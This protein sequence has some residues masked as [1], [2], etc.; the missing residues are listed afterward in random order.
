[1]KRLRGKL[2]YANVVATLALF[3]ALGGASAFAATKLAKNSVGTKQIKNGA[4]TNG[5]IKNGA[6]TG[7][8]ID[9]STLGAVP[10]AT[11]A[12]T[13][14]S[15][16]GAMTATNATELGGAPATD[17][18]RSELEPVHVVGAPGQPQ[19]EN[20]CIR[21]S[22]VSAPPSFYK[23]PFGVVHLAGVVRGCPEGGGEVFT[24]PAG[25]R[26]LEDELFVIR[27]TDNTTGSIRVDADGEVAIF[28]GGEG[29]LTDIQFR[30]N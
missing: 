18:T 24:L 7:S 28:A 17:F 29:S 22:S 3:I 1:M 5:K 11:H 12:T 14:A 10:T 19:L 26:P 13:A 9:T 4:I 21:S 16:T 2:T 30:T 23:D 15:A 27:K 8:K 25:F 6:V 20:G